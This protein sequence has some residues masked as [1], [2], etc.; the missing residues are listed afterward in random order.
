MNKEIKGVLLCMGIMGFAYVLL[1]IL[2][3]CFTGAKIIKTILIIA[4]CA[5]MLFSLGLSDK[6]KRRLKAHVQTL[7][8][9]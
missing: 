4:I 2:L 8:H 9:H 6:V 7:F 5:T 3:V 1:L